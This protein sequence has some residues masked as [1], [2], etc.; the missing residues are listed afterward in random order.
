M[1][2]S[3]DATARIK[4]P[5]FQWSFLYHPDSVRGWPGR[6][7]PNVSLLANRHNS[8]T[9]AKGVIRSGDH[10]HEL[11]ANCV[12]EKS[13]V[14]TLSLRSRVERLP[15]LRGGQQE[16]HHRGNMQF[17][18]PDRV[19]LQSLLWR[20]AEANPLFTDLSSSVVVARTTPPQHVSNETPLPAPLGGAQGVPRPAE[21]HSPSSVS[22]AVPWASSW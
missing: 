13:P 19:A 8:S 21:R 10:M 11:K 15:S 7:R 16:P 5:P 2:T 1:R 17:G 12:P 9:G 22:W 18:R 6:Q 3:H 20:L 4:P 14:E